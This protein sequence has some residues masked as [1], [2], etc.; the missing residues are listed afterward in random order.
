VF[1][2]VHHPT[3]VLAGALIGVCAGYAV[4]R[5]PLRSA[6]A[7]PAMRWM[8]A[9]PASFYAAAFFITFL[10]AEVFWPALRLVRGIAKLA[11]IA[12]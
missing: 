8:R 12:R 9:H 5:E 1:V 10:I 11:A 3:D 4:G 6:L 2:G 7:N